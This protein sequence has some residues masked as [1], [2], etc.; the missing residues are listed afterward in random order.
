MLKFLNLNSQRNVCM[1]GAMPRIDNAAYR[2]VNDS[3]CNAI[4][5]GTSSQFCGGYSYTPT[6][7]YTWSKIKIILKAFFLNKMMNSIEKRRR[8]A[9]KFNSNNYG[10]DYF[11]TDYAHH[12][13]E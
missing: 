10:K 11:N 8:M 6:N 12:Q 9:V 4:C 7:F 5:S 3:A 2:L 13:H 1:C